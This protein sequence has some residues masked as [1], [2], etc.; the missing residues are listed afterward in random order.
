MPSAE[1]LED[2]DKVVT[3]FLLCVLIVAVSVVGQGV[4]AQNEVKKIQQEDVDK[5]RKEESTDPYKKWLEADVVYIITKD[6]RDVFSKLKAAE[7]KESFIEQFWRR[8][9]PDPRTATNEFREEHYRRIAYANENFQSGLPGWQTDRGRIYIAYGPPD[10]IQS[11]PAGGAYRRPT[12]EGGGSTSTF[13]FEIWR[14][15]HIEGIGQDVELEFVDSS[16]AGEYRLAMSPEEKDALLHV[17]GAGLTAAESMGLTRK[18][19]RPYFNPGVDY[20]Y[21]TPRAKDDPFTRLEQFAK[22]KAPPKIV[23]YKDLKELV[24]VN[25]EYASLRFQTRLDFFRLNE[26]Q[27]LVPMTLEIPA[28]E[29]SFTDNGGIEEAK[30][31]LYGVISDMGSRLITEFEDDVVVRR[32]GGTS[33]EVTRC[34]YQKMLS[35][36]AKRRYK[37]QVIVK[38]QA[39]GKLG[40]YK[41]AI[42]PPAQEQDRLALSSLVLADRVDWIGRA[43]EPDERFVLGDLKVFPSL[44]RTFSIDQPLN[45]YFQIYNAGTD[46]AK[47]TPDLNISYRLIHGGNVKLEVVDEKGKSIQFFGAGR[48]VV[49]RQLPLN[50][51]PSGEYQVEIAVLDRISGQQASARDSIRIATNH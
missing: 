46:L 40:A 20:P 37:L 4:Q 44:D 6:E 17:S 8:R 42:N 36:E 23:K 41:G 34:L 39:S 22:L 25:V 51:L 24:T 5:L 14:Y 16:Q 47:L 13:P 50:G 21:Q 1:I 2:E 31:G 9:D 48:I 33:G 35:L 30:V 3:R 18:G 28:T 19:D 10:D 26:E 38:D 12:H 11:F 27:V 7:E 43:A 29:L 32:S 49:S 15:R 45:I